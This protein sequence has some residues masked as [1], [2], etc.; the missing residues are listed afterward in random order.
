MGALVAFLLC[1]ICSQRTD[2]LN[3]L[4]D[5][6]LLAWCDPNVVFGM[7]IF[8]MKAVSV[9]LWEQIKHGRNSMPKGL[10]QSPLLT[11]CV[12]LTLWVLLFHSLSSISYLAAYFFLFDSI[13][14]FYSFLCVCKLYLCACGWV[15]K[16]LYTIWALS[17]KQWKISSYPALYIS[18]F[19]HCFLLDL[20]SL[21]NRS[22]CANLSSQHVLSMCISLLTASNFFGSPHYFKCVH[23]WHES[24]GCFICTA[25]LTFYVDLYSKKKVEARQ[26]LTLMSDSVHFAH[27]QVN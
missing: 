13:L 27:F 24:V 1:S 10:F 17:K 14:L 26:G 8:R 19:T 4:A 7:G 15:H 21:L 5:A 23:V 25:L 20:L 18:A 3:L 16:R 6:G 2:K 11:S 22:W 9:Q 12:L